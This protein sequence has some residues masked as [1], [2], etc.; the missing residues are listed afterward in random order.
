MVRLSA[1]KHLVASCDSVPEDLFAWKHGLIS[2]LELGEY[3]ARVTLGDLASMGAR[4]IG[5]L[6]MVR[7]PSQTSLK[8][9]LQLARGFIRAAKRYGAPLVGGDTKESR[10]LSVAATALGEI[11][12]RRAITRRRAR[13][14]D[15]VFCT[16][17]LGLTSAAVAYFSRWQFGSGPLNHRASRVLRH[18]L[19]SPQPL[20]STGL[21][22]S[23]LGISSSCIDN[24]DGLGRSLSELSKSSS[25]RIEIDESRLPLHPLTVK[26]ARLL[27][28]N[29]VDLTLSFGLDL[30][31]IGT[32]SRPTQLRGV[33]II[34]RVCK[35]RGVG[36]LTKTRSTAA[37]ANATAFEHF[38]EPFDLRVVRARKSRV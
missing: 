15:V 24:T 3:A 8:S 6:W 7:A 26:V 4:P 23:R 14:G 16:G 28:C 17:L 38:R 25:C 19:W 2:P 18:A 21:A 12:L 36:T 37:Y 35:G 1:G 13:P 33:S 34:G 27:G 31:L 10:V 32:L 29:P 22:L 20:L 5:L 11:D 9:F 30:N